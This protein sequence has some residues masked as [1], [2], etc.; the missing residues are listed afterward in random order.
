MAIYLRAL[1]VVMWTT[2][3]NGAAVAAKNAL[4]GRV[5]GQLHSHGSTEWLRHVRA[6]GTRSLRTAA[7]SE[8]RGNL[9]GAFAPV[10]PR[11]RGRSGLDRG[12]VVGAGIHDHDHD[13][14]DP[15]TRTKSKGMSP[16]PHKL[17]RV[18]VDA[19]LGPALAVAL[20][21]P[22]SHY[23]ATVMRRRDGDL[24]RVFNGKDG[25]YLGRVELLESGA[26]R[27]R[28]APKKASVVLESECHRSQSSLM[29]SQGPLGELH[30][31]VACVKV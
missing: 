9:G 4:R 6:P 25:E 22:T 13:H 2:V 8:S 15:D 19:P 30:L 1:V 14:V 26:G 16:A 20:D 12:G 3:R 31:A 28:K 18:F 27:S 5:H 23:V 10:P 21:D 11:R 17:P 7:W 29:G 24:L